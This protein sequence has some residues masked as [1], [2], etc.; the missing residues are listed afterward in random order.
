MERSI[1]DSKGYRCLNFKKRNAA[2]RVNHSGMHA[3]QTTSL[4]I[5]SGSPIDERATQY[6][7]FF[8]TFLYTHSWMSLEARERKLIAII[9]KLQISFGIL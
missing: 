4:V 5:F 6:E 7:T 2:P 9:Y 1:V 8:Q 3:A